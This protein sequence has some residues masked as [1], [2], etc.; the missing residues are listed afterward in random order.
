MQAPGGR[1]AF[2][3]KFDRSCCRS[4]TAFHAAGFEQILWT[5][6]VDGCEKALDSFALDRFVRAEA[7]HIRDFTPLRRLAASALGFEF[8]VVRWLAVGVA[9]Q[10]VKDVASLVAVH[11]FGGYHADL[12]V[13][14]IKSG[15]LATSSGTTT[16]LGT[17]PCIAIGGQLTHQMRTVDGQPVMLWSGFFCG[18]RA[19]K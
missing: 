3:R 5:N 14:P 13:F 9:V 19:W 11:F 18:Y 8:D 17:K 6:A 12:Q 2:A 4:I 1:R 16:V 15:N 10:H 7:I